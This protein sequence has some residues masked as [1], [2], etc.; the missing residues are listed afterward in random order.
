MSQNKTTI[1]ALLLILFIAI[2]T[3]Y[4][5][6]QPDIKG[7]NHIGLRASY[8]NFPSEMS[9]ISAGPS[10]HWQISDRLVLNYHL[11]FGAD[12]QD[13]FYLRSYLG[14]GGAVLLAASAIEDD[15]WG[16]AKGL[17]AILALA[18][19]EG[20]GYTAEIADDVYLVPYINPLGFQ[21]SSE[22]FFSGET[23]VRVRFNYDN[24][25]LMPYISGEVL[26]E[27][28]ALKGIGAGLSVT[29]E[30]N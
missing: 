8:L 29:F 25:N 22:E 13:N 21:L 10:F 6:A 26:Y 28:P 5:K 30:V 24:W 3:S 12:D 17:L 1:Y 18:V 23:G 4:S 19:P 7:D 11:Q 2:F 9:V 15:E 14:G 16:A 27:D 20:I